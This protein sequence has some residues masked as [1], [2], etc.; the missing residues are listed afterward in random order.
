MQTILSLVLASSNPMSF[1][2]LSMMMLLIQRENLSGFIPGSEA[3]DSEI[4]TTNK[5]NLAA[6]NSVRP[7]RDLFLVSQTTRSE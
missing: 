3:V 2:L 5:I 1:W 4:Y 7:I 6:I